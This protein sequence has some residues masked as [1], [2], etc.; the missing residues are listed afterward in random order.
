MKKLNIIA[1]PLMASLGL[2]APITHAQNYNQVS[3]EVEVSQT[4]SNDELTATLTKSAEHADSKILANTLN[5]TTNKALALAQ[6]YPNVKATTSRHHTYPRY[7]NKGKINGFTGSSSIKITS[8]N[9]GEAS[10]LIAKLQEFMQLENL[11]FGVSESTQKALENEL[12]LQT[13]SKFS[14]EAQTITRA[15]GA[16]DYKIVTVDLSN[17]RGHITV[18][19]MMGRAMDSS[20]ELKVAPQHYESGESQITYG[21]RGVIELLK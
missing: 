15:F 20:A 11:N 16:S 14:N 13:I 9:F 1:L 3:F 10:E 17:H 21:A 7:D 2:V 18:S 8:Q 4:V 19:P 6:K 12:K 5:T